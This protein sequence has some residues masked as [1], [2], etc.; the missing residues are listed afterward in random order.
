MSNDLPHSGIADP[1][2]TAVIDRLQAARHRPAGGGPRG[3]SGS[4]DPHDYAEQGFRSIPSRA[5]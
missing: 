5:S 4:R 2:V 3:G 1:R